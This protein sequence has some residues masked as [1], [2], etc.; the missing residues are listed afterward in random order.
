MRNLLQSLR[1]EG[2]VMLVSTH[3]LGSVPEFCDRT[4]L[5]K[6][7][8]VLPLTGREKFTAVFGDDS[9]EN[10][11]GPNGCPDHG[12]DNGTLAMGWGSGTAFYPYLV[13]P[14]EAV[15]N[16]LTSKG[17]VVQSVVDN[18]DS[19]EGY[20]TVDGNMGDRN[21]LTFWQDGDKLIR[22]VIAECN[23]TIVVIHSVGPTIIEEYKNHSN[24]TAILW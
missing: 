10:P 3:N 13:T 15:K 5:L 22:S 14:L 12:C 18:A 7:T 1:A 19:G 6:N 23:N 4:V 16:E 20:I 21:N 2:R 11:Y 8:G 24:V 9:T 17:R